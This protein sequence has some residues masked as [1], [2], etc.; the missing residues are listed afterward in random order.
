M[1]GDV[2]F[3]SRTE[4]E[5]EVE[6][7]RASEDRFRTF[8]EGIETGFSIVEVRFD[9]DDRPVDYRILEANPAFE[10]YVGVNLRG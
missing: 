5:A 8:L 9:S 4:L 6:R 1:G 7:L 10:R 2:S 3:L